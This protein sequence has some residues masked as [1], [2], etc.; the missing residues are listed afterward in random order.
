VNAS[1]QTPY[2]STWYS[3]TMVAAPA[4]GPLTFDLDVD[5]CVIGA[6]L[7]GLTA[8]RE[9]AR[10]GWSV[11]V[12]E[13]RRIAWNASG[14]NDGFVLP[15]FAESMDRIVSRVG[16]DH[17]KALW[18]LS[19]MG[20]KYVRTAIAEARMPGVAPIAGWLKVSK[21][22]NGD[23]VLAAV[24]LYGQ[25]LGADVEGWP[26][27]RVREV[28]RTNHYFHAMHLPRA[29]HIHPLNY[30]LGLAEA[31]E[32]AGARIFEHTPAMSIDV[33]GVRKRIVTPS[34]RVRA[35]HIVLAC[36]VHLG[37][38]VPRI[39]GTLT[40]IWSYVLTTAP[41]GAR[42]AE[43]IAYRGAITDTDLANSH[44][45]V[46]GGDRLM[47]SGHSTT[48]EADPQR[49][50]KR[51]KADIAATYPKL[52]DVP[53]E[54]TWSGVIGNALH[55]M[56]Q[57]GEFSPGL[58]LASGF[59]G[60]G[61]NT[62]AM[63]GVVLAQAIVEGDD[64]WRLFAPFE[65]VWAGGKLGRAAVQAYYWWFD[66]R[67]RF[68]ARQAR[69]REQEF[70]RA[71]ELAALRSGEERARVEERLGAV[72]PHAQLPQEPTLAQL[73][74]DPVIAGETVPVEEGDVFVDDHARRR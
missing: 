69:Q 65:L 22:D 20:L 1:E 11:A 28:L 70:R 43:V 45:R 12:L 9:V 7:A 16:L 8:A 71:E 52:G 61:I 6:G 21:V 4:R 40:P 35:G 13:S 19:D 47:W 48:W 39:A 67:E 63:A 10:R 18:S 49:Y 46:V 3:G 41:L 2:A 55:R 50:V 32:A 24:Q 37:T 72:V 62:T 59:G 26:T 33:E 56:P 14:R 44:Y 60:H 54:H 31:A 64:S 15:G 57:I 27:E 23:E 53:V 73:P 51:L 5:V 29:F 74:V 30:A 68:E 34:A 42:L 38:L 17:A 66:A 58:W 36:N 25:E